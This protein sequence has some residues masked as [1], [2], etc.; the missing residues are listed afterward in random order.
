MELQIVSASNE[1]VQSLPGWSQC[2][3]EEDFQLRRW[4]RWRGSAA[5]EHC[6]QE[7]PLYKYL[8]PNKDVL[9]FLLIFLLTNTLQRQGQ[10]RWRIPT[11]RR[12]MTASRVKCCCCCCGLH[13]CWLIMRT[14]IWNEFSPRSVDGPERYGRWIWGI[15]VGG[16][17]WAWNKL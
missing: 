4:S 10:I 13:C 11:F 9:N 12:Q 6:C 15:H 1:W 17:P 16:Q 14:K 5:A 7:T 8:K 2:I 3:V